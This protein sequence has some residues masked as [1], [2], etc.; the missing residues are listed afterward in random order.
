MNQDRTDIEK[1]VDTML[2]SQDLQMRTNEMIIS[3]L[4][5]L[6]ERIDG[7]EHR[8]NQESNQ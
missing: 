1:A 5:E 8:M 6:K 7:L 4:R 2:E 3:L